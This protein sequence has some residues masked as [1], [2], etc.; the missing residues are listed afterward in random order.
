MTLL[1]LG[2][3]LWWAGHLFPVYLPD[4]RAAAVAR[5]GQGPYK[6]LFTLVAL[7]AIALMVIGYRQADYIA[8]W[9]PPGWA[10]HLNNL[11]MVAAVF[12]I[13]A[14]HFDS[15]V[16]HHI[17]HPM[18]TAVKI[19]AVAHLLVNG[20]LASILLFGGLLAWAVVALIGTNRRDREWTRP[21]K[22]TLAGL[23]KQGVLAALIFGAI[24]L[25]HSFVLGVYTFPQ[26]G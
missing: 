18:F 10:M 13:E 8:V 15:P 24:V 1:I 2:L 12:L 3:G 23:M 26:G 14:K 11:M 20:D 22:G 21:G 17:R 7:G 19:W 16:R 5:L 6:G 9:T 4:A 25:V